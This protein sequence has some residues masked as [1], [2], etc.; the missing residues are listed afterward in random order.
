MSE[1]KLWH[2]NVMMMMMMIKEKNSI[3]GLSQNRISL[4]SELE[5]QNQRVCIQICFCLMLF[6][7]RLRYEWLDR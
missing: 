1:K 4:M 2:S 6:I 5:E 3:T 7:H